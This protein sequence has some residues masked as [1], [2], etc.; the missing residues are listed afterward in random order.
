MLWRS[1]QLKPEAFKRPPEIKDDLK[2]YEIF[3]HTLYQEQKPAYEYDDIYKNQINILC[4]RLTTI[5]QEF[6]LDDHIDNLT[7]FP[8][9]LFGLIDNKTIKTDFV[10]IKQLLEKYVF[11]LQKKPDLSKESLKNRLAE[12][13]LYPNEIVLVQQLEIERKQAEK[14]ELRK[15]A[16]LTITLPQLLV[17][18]TGIPGHLA[19]AIQMLTGGNTIEDV[20]CD[21]RTKF[22]DDFKANHI[23]THP[24]IDVYHA[25]IHVDV[26]LYTYATQQGLGL[27]TEMNLDD[28][29]QN[30]TFLTPEVLTKVKN[31]LL[32]YYTFTLMAET[33]VSHFQKVFW[34]AF[35]MQAPFYA[36]K[37]NELVGEWY[38]LVNE[39]TSCADDILKTWN[40]ELTF[41]E[42]FEVK[43]EKISGEI[44]PRKFFKLTPQFLKQ[45]FLKYCQV[46]NLYVEPS[47]WIE[48]NKIFKDYQLVYDRFDSELAWIKQTTI[49]QVPPQF[50]QPPPTIRVVSFD[51]LP[52][53]EQMKYFIYSLVQYG[54]ADRFRLAKAKLS[55]FDILRE[56]KDYE[57]LAKAL[58]TN[59]QW[60]EHQFLLRT[61]LEE[62]PSRFKIILEAINETSRNNI[63]EI[64]NIA[65]HWL[66]PREELHQS[67]VR[68]NESYLW[69]QNH[70]EGLNFKLGNF[71]RAHESKKE[72][73]MPIPYTS[74]LNIL[75][76]IKNK[77]SLQDQF[78]TKIY[79]KKY[80][81]S[82][83]QKTIESKEPDYINT[84]L[85]ATAE[86]FKALDARAV[87]VRW[88]IQYGHLE[89]LKEMKVMTN[90]FLHHIQWAYRCQQQPILDY[91]YKKE[92]LALMQLGGLQVPLL[93]LLVLFNQDPT[94][95]E[96]KL[97][98][99][100]DEVDINKAR[101]NGETPLH[102]AAQYG[103][104]K[105]VKK[106]CA[107][108]SIN[109]NATLMSGETPLYLAAINGHENIVRLL[110]E[111][112]ANPKMSRH[113]GK[114][115][116]LEAIKKGYSNIVRLLIEYGAP[117][118][119][120]LKEETLL[121]YAIHHK[122]DHLVK[123]LLE[124]GA[125]P[126]CVNAEGA[127][128]LHLAVE[129]GNVNTA[130]L[131][132]M[133]GAVVNS[134]DS[135][136]AT[137]LFYA[138]SHGH[139]S[140]VTLL[141]EHKA[142]V[143]TQ[144]QLGYTPLSMAAQY[145]YFDIVKALLRAGANP[146]ANADGLLPYEAAKDPYIKKLLFAAAAKKNNIPLQE[147]KLGNIRIIYPKNES[148]ETWIEDAK[149]EVILFDE[150]P[151]AD[152]MQYYIHS[153]LKTDQL[154]AYHL[155]CAP[156]KLFDIFKD[157]NDFIML[158]QALK[159]QNQWGRHQWLLT[160]IFQER[161]NHFM[162]ML[163]AVGIDVAMQIIDLLQ[164]DFYWMHP[165]HTMHQYVRHLPESIKSSE[166][167]E[168]FALNLAVALNNQEKVLSDFRS[169][170]RIESVPVP[171][172]KLLE[173]AGKPEL[174]DQPIF[175][176]YLKNYYNDYFQKINNDEKPNYAQ[177]FLTAH[178]SYQNCVGTERDR[179][180]QTL[181]QH[182]NL[183]GLLE[184]KATLSDIFYDIK[185]MHRCQQREL[186]K[187]FYQQAIKE[188]Q[189]Q[190]NRYRAQT[191]FWMVAFDQHE[192]ENP[193]VS[194]LLA[195]PD[196]NVNEKGPYGETPLHI[197]VKFA[198]THWVKRLCEFK[199]LDVDIATSDGLT[200]LTSAIYRRD[201]CILRIL[202]ERNASINKK[203]GGGETPLSIAVS[204]GHLEM[205]RLLLEHK[206]TIQPDNPQVSTPFCDAVKKGNLEIM[207]LLLEHRALINPASKNNDNP[208]YIAASQG[209]IE[210]L[211]FLMANQAEI[212][213]VGIDELNGSTPLFHAVRKNE[214]NA[215]KLLIERKAS[216]D[217]GDKSGCTPLIAATVNGNLEA[218]MMLLR[219][220]ANL[221]LRYANRT[222]YQ[223]ASDLR[224]KKVL[225]V[226]ACKQTNK[227]L[228]SLPIS[229]N[230]LTIKDLR[231]VYLENSKAK[232]WIEDAKGEMVFIDRLSAEEKL[233]YF[234]H[235]IL[236]TG[237][238]DF[239]D[240]NHPAP[241]LQDVF[242]NEKDF[243][244]LVNAL[245]TEN[246]WDNHYLLFSTIFHEQQL[247]YFTQLLTAAGKEVTFK[248][249]DRLGIDFF[250]L[251]PK[252]RLYELLHNTL[253][254]SAVKYLDDKINQLR[255][256]QKR[257][258]LQQ[259]QMP[260]LYSA[261]LDI[262]KK[263]KSEDQFIFKMYF[264]AY[265]PSAYQKT[266]AEGTT[267]YALAFLAAH[268]EDVKHLDEKS[269]KIRLCIQNGDFSGL[270]RMECTFKNIFNHLT[271]MHRC[272]QM[273]LLN[274]FYKK[275]ENTVSG[276][277]HSQLFRMVTFNQQ[278]KDKKEVETL[279]VDNSC[280]YRNAALLNTATFGLTEW[281]ARLCE[282]ESVDINHAAE[283]GNSALHIASAN[284][285]IE[286]ISLLLNREDA[287]INSTNT[288][289][290]TA[291][292]IAAE[293][294]HL[295]AVHLL[296]S[297]GAIIDETTSKS[298]TTPL[299]RAAFNGHLD[300]VRLLIKAGAN[301]S[302]CSPPFEYVRNPIIKRWLLA[303]EV[304]SKLERMQ[305][306]KQAEPAFFANNDLRQ[307]IKQLYAYLNGDLTLEQFKKLIPELDKQLTTEPWKT[308]YKASL[309]LPTDIIK[310]AGLVANPI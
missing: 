63:L 278:P 37:K 279:C 91:F 232:S 62:Q 190:L 124:R 12:K 155:L 19:Y 182:G 43:E 10:K 128:P 153:I 193:E 287:K 241:R 35:R 178:A 277:M 85:N 167:E 191:L 269:Q 189:D 139:A 215:M 112:H 103:I 264:K 225:F 192:K 224:I 181:I 73:A 23:K 173:I 34:Q 86:D 49:E 242:S 104:V 52:Q 172:A 261:L 113:D 199:S 305:E 163:S 245:Q 198:L 275:L 179:I 31:D 222:A 201:V 71:Q 70:I 203:D 253:Q 288:Y 39:A 240:L 248:V 138:A 47:R 170:Y 268:K 79:L 78:I 297:R 102:I 205:V 211:D 56:K 216:V 41:N 27:R 177:C 176:L 169:K 231:L 3:I 21:L 100:T 18:H 247:N 160:M 65:F 283:E 142:E 130:Y 140:C 239:Y 94:G 157:E 180:I 308:L 274:M 306:A 266:V 294:G 276:P 229:N 187:H 272:Q 30:L 54:V 29:Y 238:V 289:G 53:E 221:S 260:I 234:I 135:R 299:C 271:W 97:L 77:S 107:H 197:A 99:D 16:T 129:R 4:T 28:S 226:S 82:A 249:I 32:A 174:G 92:W 310:K 136:N 282:S 293:N 303:A 158:A 25:A 159:T 67:I 285:Y 236:K 200:P 186:I 256:F 9:H 121:H 66:H 146:T 213:Q 219:A 161:P 292:F 51:E 237:F 69:L 209:N 265:F 133:H 132:L 196:I 246:R 195:I 202:L 81:P 188:S 301:A 58:Q 162:E 88:S 14:L 166:Q 33:F 80:F 36:D 291:L 151:A 76:K 290:H 212:N 255:T 263:A 141:L 280:V 267:N 74:F 45:S 17:C 96:A 194:S 117:V 20:W 40:F 183:T 150:L 101:Q 270:D 114:L 254:G 257:Y 258:H 2:E 123:C 204:L 171:Y 147:E 95:K 6:K 143:D 109:I 122:N 75:R 115:A 87:Q 83:Y 156:P 64:L 298:K 145:G 22:V 154:D 250:W 243:M 46:K 126:D 15:Q 111:H 26:V 120:S 233:N 218:V 42:T 152:K 148:K 164:I 165:N 210:V 116:I 118:D 105:W 230:L 50:A 106:L 144:D 227:K 24:D 302:L 217:Q 273:E 235:S 5:A 72:K 304:Q 300:I 208:L 207:K 108:K 8:N 286:I 125:H 184:V 244:A 149:G 168:T 185:W 220:G 1:Q 137:P 134:R 11:L 251:H 309:A 175:K 119:S 296:I 307:S 262:A 38:P 252:H 223:R 93:Y 281:V 57:Q 228:L 214:I 60:E 259:N 89:S 295:E 98:L 110:L 84:F 206:A 90:E 48:N 68:V 7:S 61:I 44:E 131:L 55:L 13:K 284:N 127:T 59:N